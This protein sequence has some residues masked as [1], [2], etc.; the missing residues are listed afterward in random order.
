MPAC[1]AHTLAP[2][3]CMIRSHCLMLM[4]L[5][6]L[7][8]CNLWARNRG[9][10]A[11]FTEDRECADRAK[12]Q[13]QDASR[14]LRMRRDVIAAFSNKGL[15]GAT[16]RQV[17][18]AERWKGKGI[19]GASVQPCSSPASLSSRGSITELTSEVASASSGVRNWHFCVLYGCRGEKTEQ[20][21]E[22]ACKLIEQY[23]SP[24]NTLLPVSEFCVKYERAWLKHT[25]T[26]LCGNGVLPRTLSVAGAPPIRL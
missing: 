25:R 23:K 7:Q 24:Q 19:S 26:S 5:V 11:G 21:H 6:H 15:S 10:P 17:L 20:W 8:A 22:Y 9:K 3:I 1:Y 4:H 18:K 16:P 12:Q 13:A 2:L 14:H